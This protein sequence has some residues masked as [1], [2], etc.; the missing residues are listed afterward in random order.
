M[1]IS[2]VIMAC[3]AAG[4]SATMTRCQRVTDKL[5]F[6]SLSS[7]N[8]PSILTQ[9]VM[10]YPAI[11]GGDWKSAGETASGETCVHLF[12]LLL[13]SFLSLYS[14]RGASAAGQA[15]GAKGRYPAILGGD[16]LA[17]WIP[18]AGSS[19]PAPAPNE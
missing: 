17:S 11:L 18:S 15:T 9:D 10:G 5:L 12:S 8:L 14:L 19:T 4:E 6:H 3:H 7:A 16:W 2:F 1:L 13:V